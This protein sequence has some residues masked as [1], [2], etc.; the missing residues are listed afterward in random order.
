MRGLIQSVP[1]AQQIGQHQQDPGGCRQLACIAQLRLLGEL[2]P[3]LA[4]FIR[5]VKFPLQHL[6]L[7]QSH[8]GSQRQWC[9]AGFLT[10]RQRFGIPPLRFYRIAFEKEIEMAKVEDHAQACLP[11]QRVVVR[12]VLGK[13]R[14][15]MPGKP[16]SG[17]RIVAQDGGVRPHIL[18]LESEFHRQSISGSPLYLLKSRLDLVQLNPYRERVGIHD[19]EMGRSK[20]NFV[21]QRPQLVQQSC[22]ILAP[23]H[24]LDHR[25]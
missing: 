11:L 1:F 15:D 9:A 21:G 20:N 23:G 10:Q 3:L 16:E 4:G 2:Q 22:I 24:H 18:Y 8:H 14:E 19:G 25:L 13:G 17:V 6:G 7:S 12:P 5:L